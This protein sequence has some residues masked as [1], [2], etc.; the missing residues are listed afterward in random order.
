MHWALVERDPAS[1]ESAPSPLSASSVLAASAGGAQSSA[2]M[3]TLIAEATAG[4]FAGA[5]VVAVGAARFEK[6]HVRM[7][8]ELRVRIGPLRPQSS[9]D[10]HVAAADF[11]EP[12]SNAQTVSKRLAL[13]SQPEPEPSP[14]DAQVMRFCKDAE[15][16]GPSAIRSKREALEA[17]ES[18]LSEESVSGFVADPVFRKKKQSAEALFAACAASDAGDPRRRFYSAGGEGETVKGARPE[19]EPRRPKVRV[20]TDRLGM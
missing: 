15:R 3:A 18:A 20:G 9:Y 13:L 11:A 10:V 6:N 14:Y 16:G 17:E 5:S 8:H 12:F 4:A 7:G 19:G 2:A 1:P